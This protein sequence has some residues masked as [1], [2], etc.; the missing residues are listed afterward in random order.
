MPEKN[1]QIFTYTYTTNPELVYFLRKKLPH[2]FLDDICNIWKEN[3]DLYEK[4]FS[5]YFTLENGVF[6]AK[7]GVIVDENVIEN[8]FKACARYQT[9]LP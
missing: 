4:R 1:L 9:Y 6:F 8:Y 3:K 5:M 7:K 2:Q